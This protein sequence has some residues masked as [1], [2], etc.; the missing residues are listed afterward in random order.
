MNSDNLLASALAYRNCGLSVLPARRLEKRPALPGWK[1]YQLRIPNERQILEWF[2]K[3]EDAICIVTGQVSGNLEMLDFDQAG[4]RFEAWKEKIPPELFACL[5]IETSQ[6]GG[7]HVI[8][9]CSDPINGNMKLAM[10]F[11]DGALV[12]LIETRGERGLFL[13]APTRG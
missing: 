5:V 9:R 10:G 4:D 1:N 8:Y 2:S 12:T 7:K 3:P 6:S 13:C 11:R